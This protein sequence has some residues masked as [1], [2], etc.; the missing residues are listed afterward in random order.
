MFKILEGARGT[1]H[2]PPATPTDSATS[3]DTATV[4]KYYRVAFGGEGDGWW[5]PARTSSLGSLL[6]VAGVRKG[7]W[8]EA[9]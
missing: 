5:V 4:A 3:L 7:Y 9:C 8:L 6:P 2:A 1:R